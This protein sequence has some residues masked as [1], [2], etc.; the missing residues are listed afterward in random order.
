[1]KIKKVPPAVPYEPFLH[2]RLK[3][4]ENAFYFLS[5]A[6]ESGNTDEILL[7]ISHILRAQNKA[8]L[9][10]ELSIDRSSLYK[11]FRRKGK[12]AFETV[13]KVL[14]KSGYRL[15]PKPVRVIA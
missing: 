14:A 15:V 1:M 5:V 3:N 13:L 4:R 12:P 10:E 6:F 11:M 9:A 8:K 7:A 2:K